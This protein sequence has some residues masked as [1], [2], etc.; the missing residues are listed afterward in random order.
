MPIMTKQRNRH[1]F[2]VVELLVSMLIGLLVIAAATTFHR[3]QILT[4]ANQNTQVDIQMGTRAAVELF[5][6]EARNIGGDVECDDP[7]LDDTLSEASTTKIKFKIGDEWITYEIDTESS[8]ARLVRYEGDG[9]PGDDNEIVD[10]VVANS[11]SFSYYNA[12]GTL[13]TAPL[14]D[15]AVRRAVRRIRLTLEVQDSAMGT[16]SQLTSSSSTNVELRNRYFMG[17]NIWCTLTATPED[18]PTPTL[19]PTSDGTTQP[20]QI[21]VSPTVEFTQ[22]PEPTPLVC[23]ATLNQSCSP[24]G[25]PN[26]C[27]VSGLSCVLQGGSTTNYKCQLVLVSTF[28]S[29]PA[30]PTNTPTQAN[31]N[32][33]TAVPPTNSP[34]PPPTSTNTPVPPTSTNTPAPPTNTHTPVPPSNTPTAANTSTRTNT[35]PP[36]PTPTCVPSGVRPPGNCTSASDTRCC[37]NA[38]NFSNNQR[39]Q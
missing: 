8:P 13:L 15:P 25:F 6:R 5:A 31:T 18:T 12:D 34:T 30:P 26:S 35:L 10:G 14:E 4:I 9:E 29:T 39:C 3:S 17:E 21:T 33:N 2:T 11:S 16:D 36:S 22:T 32:T 24:S 38:C 7:D 19:A 23:T 28:T 20:T 27:C 1:G 37:S